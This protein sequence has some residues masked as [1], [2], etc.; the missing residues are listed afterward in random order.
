M[1]K[2][3]QGEMKESIAERKGISSQV[4]G[5]RMFRVMRREITRRKK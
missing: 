1:E 2:K 3:R 4:R 5:E